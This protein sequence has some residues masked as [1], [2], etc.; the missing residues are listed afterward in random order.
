MTTPT[1]TTRKAP[2][3]AAKAPTEAATTPAPAKKAAAK[4]AEKKAT[5]AT[6]KIR[7][8]ANGKKDRTGNRP[9]VGVCGEREYRID[10]EGDAW[11]ATVTVDG[12]TETLAEGVS[13]KV[14][15]T[16]CTARNKEAQTPAAASAA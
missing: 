4:P 12:T 5:A 6:A 15:W 14:A 7:W 1:K 2:A 13:G 16:R 9:A 11:T 8:T 10:G 3:T